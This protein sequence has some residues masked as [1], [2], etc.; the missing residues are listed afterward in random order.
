MNLAKYAKN[1]RTSKKIQLREYI[2][3]K[4]KNLFPVYFAMREELKYC[5]LFNIS[6]LRFELLRLSK[7][8][9]IDNIF[10]INYKDLIKL[11]NDNKR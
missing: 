8:E 4:T 10:Q 3:K 7:E 1:F 11:V 2:Q 5:A 9:K 6:N